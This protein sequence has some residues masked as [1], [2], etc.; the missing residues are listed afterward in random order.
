MLR[1]ATLGRARGRRRRR[2]RRCTTGP[3]LPSLHTGADRLSPE[4]AAPSARGAAAA[5]WSERAWHGEASRCRVR[6]RYL[7][8]LHHSGQC[9]AI[10]DAPAVASY[11]YR[12]PEDE[13][14]AISSQCCG[15]ANFPSD[16]VLVRS[17]LF[18][19]KFSFDLQFITNP[20]ILL[21]SFAS[22][23]SAVVRVFV[24]SD[25]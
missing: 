23:S 3:A 17:S 20:S 25:W 6:R 10:A 4:R 15:V 11:S 24:T 22:P 19:R 8:D 5:R 2:C 12:L 1:T 7:L 16:A 13:D 21:L 18:K 14:D 9:S